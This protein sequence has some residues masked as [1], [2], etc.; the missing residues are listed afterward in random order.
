MQGVKIT[1][2][3]DEDILD[4]L[5]ITGDINTDEIGKYKLVYTVTDLDGNIT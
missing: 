3:E 2:D 4:R 5:V 1:D